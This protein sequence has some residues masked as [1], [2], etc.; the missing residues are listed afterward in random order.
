MNKNFII[1]C[2]DIIDQI[3]LHSIVGITKYNEE[4]RYQVEYIIKKMKTMNYYVWTKKMQ[5][6]MMEKQ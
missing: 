3:K 5:Y 2:M 6:G 4:L 1:E